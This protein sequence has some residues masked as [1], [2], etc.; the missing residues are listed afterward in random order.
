MAISCFRDMYL[1]GRSGLNNRMAEGLFTALSLRRKFLVPVERFSWL[2]KYALL[3]T[4]Y[5]LILS[6]TYVDIVSPGNSSDVYMYYK[7]NSTKIVE[8]FIWAL[9]LLPTV[10]TAWRRPSDFALTILYFIGL[11]PTLI[12]YGEADQPRAAAYTILAGYLT[13]YA[14]C[15]VPVHIP[16]LRLN[17]GMRAG[18][19]IA[20]AGAAIVLGWFLSHFDSSSLNI[21]LFAIYQYRETATDTFNFGPLAYFQGWAPRVLVPFLFCYFFLQKKWFWF[22]FTFAFQ[23]VFLVINQEKTVLLPCMIFPFMLLS[24]GGPRGQLRFMS[25]MAMQ[26]IVLDIPAYAYD[27]NLP[28]QLWTRRFFFDQQFLDYSYML[29]FDHI[30]FVRFSDSF[31]S[32]VIHYPFPL[33]PGNMVGYYIFG[34]PIANANTGFFGTG[35]MELGTLGVILSGLIAGLVLK[36]MDRVTPGGM[37]T[38]FFGT[39]SFLPLMAMLVQQ[40]MLTSLLTGGVAVLMV[41]LMG[42]RWIEIRSGDNVARAAADDQVLAP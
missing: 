21:D 16:H 18:V 14:V 17:R 7:P 8:A 24:G 9:A 25:L 26:I 11:I 32:G 42:M 1:V 5:W 3:L 39:V 36:L 27:F 29:V 13:V 22:A 23:A 4:A 28:A 37:P 6:Y 35:Y 12:I 2:G 34:L 15:R 31:L 10:N 30:G 41:L 19:Y 38:W 40:N 33:Q 20:A